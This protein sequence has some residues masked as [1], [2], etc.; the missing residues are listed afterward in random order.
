[1]KSWLQDND[2]CIQHIIKDLVNLKICCFRKIFQNL[3]ESNLQMYDFNIL[4]IDESADIFNECN[5]T[6]QYIKMKPIDLKSSTYIDFGVENNG[7]NHE[8]KVHDHVSNQNQ[9]K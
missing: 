9:I 2:R 1:M 8:F 4:Y 7:K 3:E 5:N 6:L